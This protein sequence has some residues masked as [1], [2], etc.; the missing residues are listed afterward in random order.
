VGLWSRVNGTGAVT[1]ASSGPVHASLAL[2]PGNLVVVGLSNFGGVLTPSD[3]SNTYIEIG[4]LTGGSTSMTLYYTIVTTGGTLTIG[5]ATS[6]FAVIGVTQFSPGGGT[7]TVDGT[8][9]TNANGGTASASPNSGSIPITSGDLVVGVYGSASTG[10]ISPVM[11][12]LVDAN[13]ADVSGSNIAGALLYELNAP[14]ATA[15]LSGTIPASLGWKFVAGAFTSTGG[16]APSFLGR[17]TIYRRTGS[18]G[19]A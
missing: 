2:T 15:V 11:P 9:V 10:V 6:A 18:R 3:G 8:A 1:G 7:I 5:S 19:A 13:F 17:R 14:G 16:G 12:T 4:Q